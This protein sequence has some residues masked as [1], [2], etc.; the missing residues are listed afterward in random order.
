MVGRTDREPRRGR[1]NPWVRGLA[2]AAAV[3]AGAALA[4]CSP[5]DGIFV[6]PSNQPPAAGQHFSMSNDKPGPI[7][8]A[9]NK[10]W[11]LSAEARNGLTLPGDGAAIEIRPIGPDSAYGLWNATITEGAEPGDPDSALLQLAANPFFCLGQPVGRDEDHAELAPCT[12]IPITGLYAKKLEDGSWEFSR[13]GDLVL[14]APEHP[15]RYRNGTYQDALFLSRSDVEDQNSGENPYWILPTLQTHTSS[16]TGL[17]DNNEKKKTPAG[18]TVDTLVARREQD[19]ESG[20]PV[21]SVPV[22]TL[23]NFPTPPPTHSA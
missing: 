17:I 5:E 20:T 13:P 9:G 6:T 2:G 15:Q 12:D 22:A 3:A 4:G 19:D 7:Y 11:G 10:P 23:R 1:R 18:N 16:G 21:F 14:S 8:T